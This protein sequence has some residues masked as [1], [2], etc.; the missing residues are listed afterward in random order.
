MN[1]YF[2]RRE[3][4]PCCHSRDVRTL[5]R[6][7]YADGPLKDYLDRFYAVVGGVDHR[8]LAGS[9]FVAN[10]CADCGAVYQEEIPNGELMHQLYDVWMEPRKVLAL[11]EAGYDLQHY[12]YLGRQVEMVLRHF[13]V[14]P[15][16]LT[17]LDFGMGWGHWCRF[18]KAYGC[19]T[20]GLESSPVRIEYARGQGIEVLSY[21]ELAQHRFHM[22]NA[23]QVFEHLTDPLDTLTMLRERLHPQGLIWIGVPDG[24]DILARIEKW[25]WSAPKG[26]AES[27]NPLA[28]LE[29][30]NCFT[31]DALVTMA[32]R[33]GLRPVE[34]NIPRRKAK[35]PW[36]RRVTNRPPPVA[37]AGTSGY[38]T[39]LA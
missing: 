30:L 39:P 35:W 26:S 18:A 25:N 38:F 11:E 27:L 34:L 16:G 9:D 8:F 37:P 10:V 14:L 28:P 7:P 4:C 6:A 24:A 23:E 29:H 3:R 1:Q 17:F 20:F 5:R 15:G 2:I 13:G 32:A 19:R 12:V 33:A 22:I 21:A 36:W 31:P